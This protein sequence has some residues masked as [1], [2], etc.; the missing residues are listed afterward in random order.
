MLFDR[1]DKAAKA[2]GASG[3]GINVEPQENLPA[4]SEGRLARQKGESVLGTTL[5]TTRL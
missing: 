5:V 4:G 1:A 3:L 2:M